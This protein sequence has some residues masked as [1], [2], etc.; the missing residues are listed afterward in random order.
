[1]TYTEE[2]R[3]IAEGLARFFSC[4]LVRDAIADMP[5]SD[6]V[7]KSSGS[8]H[9]IEPFPMGFYPDDNNLYYANGWGKHYRMWF[10]E[11]W[12]IERSIRSYLKTLEKADG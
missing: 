12:L 1:M 10:W 9:R 3:R 7:E 8:I 6:W 11:K 4:K 2:V 5:R